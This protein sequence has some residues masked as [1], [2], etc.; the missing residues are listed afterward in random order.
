MECVAF[1]A[2]VLDT[3]AVDIVASDPSCAAGLVLGTRE[4]LAG[5]GAF[6]QPLSSA[7]AGALTSS[8][9]LLFITAFLFGFI[10]RFLI[11]SRR[12]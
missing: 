7:E 4:E 2:V 9:V 1:R 12:E 3:Q 5:L 6:I 10:F 11:N 8:V